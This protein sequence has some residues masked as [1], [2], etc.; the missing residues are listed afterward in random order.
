MS[1]IDFIRK[2]CNNLMFNDIGYKVKI[3]DDFEKAQFVN[4][5]LDKQRGRNV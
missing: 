2:G 4:E 1:F 3:S 5:K